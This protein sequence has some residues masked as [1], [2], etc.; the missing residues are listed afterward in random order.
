MIVAIDKHD[1]AW[2]SKKDRVDYVCERNRRGI[3]LD[4]SMLLFKL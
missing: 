4:Y 3:E 1:G 2:Y